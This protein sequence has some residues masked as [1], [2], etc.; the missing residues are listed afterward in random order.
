MLENA[1]AQLH[2]PIRAHLERIGLEEPSDI[3]RIA[4]PPILEGKTVLVIAPTGTGK[5]LASILP[6]FHMFLE[7]R[8]AGQT[9]GI[10][11]LYVTPLRALNRDIVRRLSEIGK[12][13]DIRVQVRHGDTPTSTRVMQAKSPPEMLVTTP[14]TLQAILPGRRMRE[15]L[16]GVR[17]VVVDEIH[18]LATDERGVQ[19]SLALERLHHL[20]GRDFQRIG[21]SATVGEERK[22]GEFLAGT[23]RTVAIAKS[24]EL[25]EFNVQ[26]QYVPPTSEDSKDSDKYG[27]PPTTIA[28]AKE[29]ARIISEKQSTLVF[30]NTREQAE[31]V[32]SQLHALAPHLS[33]RVHHG[34][35]S[36]EIREEVEKG[37]QDGSVKGVICTSSLELG[38]DVGSVDFIVQYMSPRM[39]TRLIQRIGRSGHTLKGLAKGTIIGTWADDL[40]EAAVIASNS[41]AGRIER[42]LIHDKSLDVLA[43][44]I[45]GIALDLKRVKLSQVFEI[46]HGSY[47]YRDM[48]GEQLYDFAK[49]LNSLGIIRLAE[50]T[51]SP[52][53]PRTFRYYYENLSVIP[54]VKRF[55]VFDFFRKRRIGTLDQ[56]FVA[57]KC[58]SGTVFII[59]G[60]TWKIIN[61]NEEKLSVEVEPTVPTLDAIPSW[62][63]EIIPVSFE[64]AQ[65]VGGLRSLVAEKL[66][67]LAELQSVQQSLALTEAASG[68]VIESVRAQ[69]RH[70]PLPSDSHLIIEKFENCIVIHACFGNLVNDTLAMILAS[71]LSAKFGM[72]MATQTDPY[73]IALIS[74]FKIEPET[75]AQELSKLT[76]DD[77]ETILIHALET[78]DLFAWRHWHVARRFGIVERKADYRTN[79]ARML[80]RAMKE[81]PVNFETLREVLI[82]KFDLSTAKNV[83]AKIQSGEI[84]IDIAK[85][86]AESCSPYATPIIDKII[87]H[88]LLRP[89]VPSKSLTDIVKERLLT[90]TV[91]LV[92]MFNGDWDAVRVVG[93]LGEKIHC[94]KC[95]STL[96]AAT[97]QSNDSLLTIVR[98]KKKGAKL[99]SEEEHNWRQSS[100]SASLVQ[101]N[102]KHAVI[103]MTGRGVG[104]T[105]ATRILRRPHRTEQDLY[106]D[107]VKAEREYARTRLFWD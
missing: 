48:T 15:H 29:I 17:W 32:G 56:D 25:K 10:S 55:D 54:D 84:V 61:V 102:G 47:P 39:S 57:R 35:L 28:R 66:E 107:I 78:S 68:K 22:V 94:P 87:P 18:E 95:R 34:S 46:V 42:T 21:L 30:T 93:D 27:L 75:V 71:L 38:I 67:D 91:R 103:V 100:L 82:E 33:V 50:D 101:T 14:E 9:K 8:S 73:R 26:V 69:L 89:A 1:F 85:E 36:R 24:E 11:I 7:Q 72:N 76:P 65:E 97:Y 40:L 49:F 23:G 59:H 104:P 43:H 3:Q 74:P 6:I 19:L 52:R 12:E 99:T 63:G 53:F 45:A 64:T 88:D 70:F 96:I 77:V 4:I 2:R 86:Q 37:F 79:R 31:A 44:Q 51:V 80:V 41:K 81:T 106:V 92:C 16:K 105:T 13:L 83:V 5:T 62:E 60:Q 58:K 20:T 98:K 90:G